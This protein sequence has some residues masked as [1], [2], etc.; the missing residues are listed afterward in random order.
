MGEDWWLVVGFAPPLEALGSL[1]LSLYP[2]LDYLIRLNPSL[3][4]FFAFSVCKKKKNKDYIYI[5]P[6]TFRKS[7][8]SFPT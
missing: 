7:V 4:D 2:P 3:R 6:L 1:S 8:Y 5:L